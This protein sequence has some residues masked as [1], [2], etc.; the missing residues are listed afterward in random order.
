MIPLLVLL[1]LH[2]AWPP[3]LE[4]SSAVACHVVQ[5]TNVNGD[6]EVTHEQSPHI[7]RY[8][9]A[10]GYVKWSSGD[11]DKSDLVAA[12]PLATRDSLDR[13]MKD[14]SQFVKDYDKQVLKRRKTL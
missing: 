4:Y 14:C 3:G 12:I 10:C 13:S 5:V 7:A 2:I 8:W 9:Q 6:C 11:A 1:S